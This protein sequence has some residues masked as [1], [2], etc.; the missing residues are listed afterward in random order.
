MSSQLPPMIESPW[1]IRLRIVPTTSAIFRPVS[2]MD[3]VD[4]VWSQDS[5]VLQ[6]CSAT[7]AWQ[8]CLLRSVLKFSNEIMR[9]S[10]LDQNLAQAGGE[11]IFIEC[12][13]LNFGQ[14]DDSYSK[15]M[16]SKTIPSSTPSTDSHL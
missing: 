10:N 6:T 14:K 13:A 1:L 11:S 16:N 7:I 15:L 5:M 4:V 12:E 2:W 8:T 3:R 9:A